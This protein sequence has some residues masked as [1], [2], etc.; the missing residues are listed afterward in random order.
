MIADDLRDAIWPDVHVAKWAATK[1]SFHLFAQMLGKTR[2]ALSP[3]Q[4]NW[5]FTALYLTSRGLTTGA[6]PLDDGSLEARIDALSSEIRLDRSTGESIT[7]SLTP[8][9]TVAHVYDEL[10]TALQTLRA[11]CVITPIPQEL[12][13]VTPFDEDDRPGAYDPSAVARW[14]HS[15]TTAA[16][17]FDRWRSRFFGRS[18]VQVW[19]GAL[20]VSL[21]LFN[22]KKVP[23]PRDRGYLLRYDLDAELMNV[24]LYY[25]DENTAPFFY[26][27]IYP[28]PPDAAKLPIAPAAASWS[29]KLREWVL[30]YDAVRD[31]ADPVAELRAFLDGMYH[32]C[33]TVAGWDDASLTYD[34]PPRRL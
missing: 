12:P 13:D 10:K 19:W 3:T 21:M 33:V 15:A 25:G 27:Y 32:L 1:R 29:D 20:D 2:L 31:A 17:I 22:G 6:M 9:R 18:G 8:A 24:G 34:A 28:E 23:A 5:M 4:P 30:P 16:T 14:F 11:S 26:G 7:L